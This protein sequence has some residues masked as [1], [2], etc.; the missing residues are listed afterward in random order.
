MRC[1]F[2]QTAPPSSLKS[3]LAREGEERVRQ[4]A[5]RLLPRANSLQ[6]AFCQG[7]LLLWLRTRALV[8]RHSLAH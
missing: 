2:E 8:S 6:Q 4:A 1:L 3:K 7:V 5:I